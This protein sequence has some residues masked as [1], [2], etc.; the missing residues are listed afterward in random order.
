[1]INFLYNQVDLVCMKISTTRS[2]IFVSLFQFI[3][4]DL[5]LTADDLETSWLMEFRF[6]TARDVFLSLWN[7]LL[8]LL[9]AAERYTLCFCL[10]RQ[11]FQKAV[12]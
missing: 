10:P 2:L 1:M 6:A 5:K 7:V 9:E 4:D 11:A 8:C 3:A 12:R